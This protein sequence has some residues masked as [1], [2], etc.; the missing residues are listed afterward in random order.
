MQR[1]SWKLAVRG[2]ADYSVSQYA[3][4]ISGY[5]RPD[6]TSTVTLCDQVACHPRL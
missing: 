5:A 3:A 4:R 1:D 2:V 6:V